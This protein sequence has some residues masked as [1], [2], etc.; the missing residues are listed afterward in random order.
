MWLLGFEL[1]TS[2]EQS[3]LLT[4]EP[5]LQPRIGSL[6]LILADLDLTE[7]WS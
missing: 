6:Y 3:M 2:E 5:S 1:R 7:G 4:T